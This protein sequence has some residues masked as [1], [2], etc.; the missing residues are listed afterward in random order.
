MF[1]IKDSKNNQKIQLSG[2]HLRW[3]ELALV[4]VLQLPVHL[5]FC[6]K[7]RDSKGTTRLSKFKSSYGWFIDCSV[8]P[9]SGGRKR[10]QVPT[11]FVKKG[12]SVFWEMISDFILCYEKLKSV[13]EVSK[14]LE[15][16]EKSKMI[17]NS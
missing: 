13:Q 17:A 3:F 11:G 7:L 4:E 12:W 14:N 1:Y 8:W 5:F 2:A 6:K 10:L 16:L 15:H 9:L